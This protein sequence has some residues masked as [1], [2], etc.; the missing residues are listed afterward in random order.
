MKSQLTGKEPDAGKDSEQKEKMVAEDELVREHHQL[1]G[2][3]SE[4][5]LRDSGEAWHARVHGIAQNL[6]QFSN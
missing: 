2:R 5:T 6:M 3:E 4:Q 1:N